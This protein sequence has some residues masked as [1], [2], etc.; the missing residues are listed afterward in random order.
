MSWT[1]GVGDYKAS[2][3]SHGLATTPGG[4]EYIAIRLGVEGEEIV[5]KIWL[6]EK[7]YGM[8]R[9]QLKMCGFDIDAMDLSELH[10]NKELLAGNVVPIEVKDEGKYGLQANIATATP[11][12]KDRMGAITARLRSA[13]KKGDP[14]AE[15]VPF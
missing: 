3:I 2:I 8:A 11:V 14:E 1:H 5:A 10:A 7:S 4:S 9:R 15:E 13:K 6:T 12:S